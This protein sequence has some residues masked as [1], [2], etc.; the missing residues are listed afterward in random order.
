MDAPLLPDCGRHLRAAPGCAAGSRRRCQAGG[1][2]RRIAAHARAS[3]CCYRVL[4]PRRGRGRDCGGREKPQGG[5]RPCPVR[6]PSVALPRTLRARAHFSLLPAP[7]PSAAVYKLFGGPHGFMISA[8]GGLGVVAAG[9]ARQRPGEQ[10]YHFRFLA[11]KPTA[12]PPRAGVAEPDDQHGSN[13]LRFALAVVQSLHQ[14]RAGGGCHCRVG[15]CLGGR[16]P[17]EAAG[18]PDAWL[19]PPLAALE[20]L[21]AGRT[22]AGCA[23]CRSS[24]ACGWLAAADPGAGPPGA[25][26]GGCG[27]CDEQRAGVVGPAGH[28]LAHLPGACPLGEGSAWHGA[29]SCCCCRCCVRALGLLPAARR[30]PGLPPPTTSLLPPSCLFQ[31]ESAS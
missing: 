15:G 18:S 5:R 11:C 10:S 30:R 24:P 29:G 27:T 7:A 8:G 23:R 4:V 17:L 21:P 1:A 3:P 2:P 28:H 25:R 16:L 6:A 31:F 9:G 19:Q 26:A 12:L 22:A 14:V 20:G 13:M